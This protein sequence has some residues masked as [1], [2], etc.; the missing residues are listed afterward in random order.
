[1]KE[2]LIVELNLIIDNT[3]I[4]KLQKLRKAV[5]DIY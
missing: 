5:Q 2:Y 4:R 3:Q 1:M